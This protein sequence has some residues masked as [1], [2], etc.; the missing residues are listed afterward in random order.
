M[1]R[2]H[3]LRN[4]AIAALV[5]AIGG[6]LWF[7]LPR[8]AA[9]PFCFS[10]AHD[11]QFG[12]RIVAKPINIGTIVKGVTYYYPETPALQT[13][14][15]KQGFYI[16]PYESTGGKVYAGSFFGPSTRAAVM[17]FQKKYGIEQT[18]E[19]GDA[20]IDKLASLYSCPKSTATS[21]TQTFVASTTIAQ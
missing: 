18:G 1:N 5:V 9:Q 16:D 4:V 3:A 14:L 17:G 19:V 20:T 2:S 6:A 11:M 15:K 7:S 12:D 13:A 21:S 10:F 8:S